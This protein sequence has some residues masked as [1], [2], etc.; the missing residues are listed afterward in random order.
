[1][2][3]DDKKSPPIIEAA[4]LI[5][6][7]CLHEPINTKEQSSKHIIILHGWN[8]GANDMNKMIDALLQIPN[9]NNYYVW[10]FSYETWRTGFDKAAI[11]L[12]NKI[13]QLPLHFNNTIFFTYSMGGLIARQLI[14]N[15]MQCTALI[16]IC[17]PHDGILPNIPLLPWD[18]GEKSM[19]KDSPQLIA[20]K[21]HP[22]DISLRN[23]F[24]CFGFGYINNEGVRVCDDKI[25]SLPSALAN[26]LK[27]IR[28]SLP[29][30]VRD[31]GTL[32][33]HHLKGMDPY[34]CTSVFQL[35]DSLI[36]R[37]KTA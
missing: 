9:V 5:P 14:A 30:Y 17:T 12:E 16:T 6:I 23:V 34:Y 13:D 10:S 32:D 26:N 24:Y 8:S 19:L 37:E 35:I 1:M 27:G 7:R 25:V 2:T 31:R 18:K 15:G 33:L 22:R 36:N 20:L 28:Y 21:N 29:L 3:I 11:L 4:E